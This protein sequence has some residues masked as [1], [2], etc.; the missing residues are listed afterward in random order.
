MIEPTE[1]ESRE[2]LDA[3][4]SAMR[5][6]EREARETPKLVLEAPH[7]APVGRL[8]EVLAARMLTLREELSLAGGEDP[9][10]A[11]S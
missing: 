6:I 2:T 7:N 11:S 9:C 1:T 10:D 5:K 4:V 8:D 3:F